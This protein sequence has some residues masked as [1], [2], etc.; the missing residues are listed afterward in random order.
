MKILVLHILNHSTI[1]L[2]NS[3]NNKCKKS[4]R[5]FTLIYFTFGSLKNDIGN[6]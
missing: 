6:T 2:N 1:K 5:F 3:F 4:Y